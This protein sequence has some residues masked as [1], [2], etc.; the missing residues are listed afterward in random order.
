MKFYK[1]SFFLVSI[2]I[3][4]YNGEKTIYKTI[5]SILA[6]N[7]E[8]LEILISNNASTDRTLEIINKLRKIQLP[9]EIKKKNAGMK[10]I[11]NLGSNKGLKQ[12]ADDLI[13]LVRESS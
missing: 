10:K 8:N 9:I 4:V 13:Y 12:I 6:Q 2:C 1:K 11:F 5:K 7:F 3:P